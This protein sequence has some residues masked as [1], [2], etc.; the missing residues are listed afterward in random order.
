MDC[1]FVFLRALQLLNNNL[2]L[3]G[4]QAFLV[5]W[6]HC[7]YF[8]KAPGNWVGITFAM[9]LLLKQIKG[10]HNNPSVQS[11]HRLWTI[12]QK[13][14]FLLQILVYLVSCVTVVVSLYAN[15]VFS[16]LK[17]IFNFFAA[18]LWAEFQTRISL[19][20]VCND[21]QYVCQWCTEYVQNLL[22]MET[23]WL[24]DNSVLILT[25]L[26]LPLCWYLTILELNIDS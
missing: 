22:E 3:F 9:S 10:F 20:S 26:S 4:E 14:F 6:Q 1:F 13:K 16:L 21:R 17:R 25:V 19:K 15:H 7:H 2:D 18:I 11:S 5:F 12:L 23:D 8:L 24:D